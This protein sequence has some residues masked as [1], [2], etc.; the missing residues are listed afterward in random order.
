MQLHSYQYDALQFLAANGSAGIFADP[1]LG[2]TAIVL[3]YIQ[4]L[5]L[6]TDRLRCLIIAPLRVCHSVWPAEVKKWNLPL[7]YDVLHGD[8]KICNSK[9]EIQLLNCENIFWFFDQIQGS[10]DLL[11]VDE[12]TK[13]KSYAAKRFKILKKNLIRFKQHIILTGTPIPKGY[14]D[15]YAQIYLLDGGRLLG[16]NITQYRST[17]FISTAYR[18]FNEY[19][20]APGADRQIDERIAPVV[21]RID[22][23]TYLDLPPLLVNDVLVDLPNKARK[24][25]DKAES[26]LIIELEANQQLIGSAAIAYNVCRQIANGRLYDQADHTVRA[27]HD[28]KIQALQE[29]VESLNGKPVLIGYHY[30]HDLDQIRTYLNELDVKYG[31]LNGSTKPKESLQIL[32]DWSVDRL[33]VLVGHPQS[34]GHG[35]NLQGS[36][37]DVIWFGLPDNLENYI[38]F[39]GRV[40]RQ[41]SAGQVRIHRLIGRST[42]EEII[43][44]RLEL[45]DQQQRSL[46]DALKEHHNGKINRT[47]NCGFN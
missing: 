34:M 31:M 4:R 28:Q 2:K 27:L 5:S 23:K 18:N 30:H 36:C 6:L 12:S 22:A 8:N 46:L 40:H 10:Y 15:L 11:V 24:I 32:A 39:N 35:L 45:K 21:K 26:D 1:G 42:I 43:A 37:K 25:Y 47:E 17:Y 20:L 33:S 29:I 16:R 3:H 13:F 44:K 41:G 7:T 38:Q 14:M 9:A 19:K